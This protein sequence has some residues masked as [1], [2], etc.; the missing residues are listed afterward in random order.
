MKLN[1][2][3]FFFQE[4]KLLYSCARAYYVYYLLIHYEF[5]MRNFRDLCKKKR[6]KQICFFLSKD[7][8]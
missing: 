8:F 4:K 2:E 3:H 1:L 7:T 6:T 5:N